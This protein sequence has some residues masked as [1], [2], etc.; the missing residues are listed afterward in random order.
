MMFK[1]LN[2]FDHYGESE[3][4]EIAKGKYELTTT[5]KGAWKQHKRAKEWLKRKS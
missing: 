2:D 1:L 4:I 3:T 5:I